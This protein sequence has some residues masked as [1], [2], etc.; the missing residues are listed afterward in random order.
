MAEHIF[1]WEDEATRSELFPRRRLSARRLR[2]TLDTFTHFA[3]FHGSRVDDVGMFYREGLQISDNAALDTR[4]RALFVTSEFPTITEERFAEAVAE[5]G[6]R[7][8]GKAYVVID[9][10]SLL[11]CGGGYFIYGIE[12]LGCLA[13]KF[14]LQEVLKRSGTPVL[15]EFHIPA[16]ELAKDELD[17]LASRIG[18][19]ENRRNRIHRPFFDYSIT[20]ERALPAEWVKGHRRPDRIRDP[21]NC[22][23]IYVHGMR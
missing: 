5:L 13:A 23:S 8:H 2:A 4:A 22:G 1:R 11:Q 18:R 6:P 7:D 21:F 9:G 17:S 3:C 14:G 15:V 10:H 12:R 19:L 20:F 16:N